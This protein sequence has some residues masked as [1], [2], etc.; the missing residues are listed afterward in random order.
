VAVAGALP[1]AAAGGWAGPAL[2]CVIVAVL[3]LRAR[4][5]ADPAPSRT[6][7]G[8]AVAG[9]AGL[10]ILAAARPE[11]LPRLLAIGVLP[12]VA[13]LR[14]PTRRPRSHRRPGATRAAAR[15]R[16]T[17]PRPAARPGAGDPGGRAVCTPAR[18]RTGHPGRNGQ[19]L[20]ADAP[21]RGTTARHRTRP[22][23]RR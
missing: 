13:C 5:Y 2:A 7:L 17:A 21:R 6:L 15:L 19:R 4:G 1:A 14:G 22:S 9:V 18:R 16:R 23:D 12:A 3:A 20:G 11:P 8:C 10:A